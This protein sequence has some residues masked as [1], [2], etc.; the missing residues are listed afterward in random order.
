MYSKGDYIIY[1]INGVC[2]VQDLMKSE[3]SGD[4]KVYYIL[5]PLDQGG[6]KIFTPVDNQKVFMRPLISREEAVKLIEGIPQY[7]DMMLHERQDQEQEYK[8]ILQE[9]D[10]TVYLRFI[11]A[12]YLKSE[13]R[14]AKGK[15]ITAIDERYL[16]LAKRI[17]LSELS[18]VLDLTVDDV[19]RLLAQK[20]MS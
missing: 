16:T 19:D 14:E 8:K 1:G 15:R 5:Q 20:F 17:L 18:V 4:D 2:K 10:C 6:S 12:L 9:Y 11:K 13:S 3:S 7:D